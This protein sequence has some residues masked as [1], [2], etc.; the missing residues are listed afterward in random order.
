[1]YIGTN[2]L[3]HTHSLLS[4]DPSFWLFVAVIFFFLLRKELF[5]E[6][7][8]EKIPSACFSIILL[9]NPL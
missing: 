6:Q 1:M 3:V 2:T 9:F 4:E 7:F 8:N 5:E